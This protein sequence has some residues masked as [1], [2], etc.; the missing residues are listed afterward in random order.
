ML[1]DTIDSFVDTNQWSHKM[2]LTAFAAY[3]AYFLISCFLTVVMGFLKYCLLP[4]K[5]LHARYG[6]GWALVTGSSDGIGK[7]Y[8]IELAKSGF[9]IVLMARN[10]KKTQQAADEIKRDY[11][12]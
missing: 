12:V 8:A 5:N 10:Q 2:L 7:Q 9:N 3:G 1:F 4:R 11:K 6:G